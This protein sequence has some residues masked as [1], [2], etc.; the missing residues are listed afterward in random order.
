MIAVPSVVAELRFPGWA[1]ADQVPVADPDDSVGEV[2]AGLTMRRFESAGHIVACRADRFVGLARIEDVLAANPDCS[3][4]ELVDHDAPTIGPGVDAEIAAWRAVRHG[5]SALAVV[6]DDGVF[7]GLV[8]PRRIVEVLL[9]EHDE[10]VARFGGYL[11]SASSARHATEEPLTARLG[12]RLPWLVLG[13][14]GAV[15]AAGIVGRFEHDL[16]DHLLLA[17]FVPG[18]VYMADA[19]GTQTEAIVI[20]G[21]SVGVT[22]RHVIRGELITG[23]VIGAALAAAFVPIGLLLWG[24]V[25]VI[26]AVAV[27]LFAACSTATF[28]AMS[29][30]WAFSRL[31]RDPAFGSGPLA[32]VIQDLLSLLMYFALASWLVG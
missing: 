24:D 22:I 4:D 14:L 8:P 10:D 9:S 29:L 30:P 18:V 13:L 3:F 11:A 2:R 28:V 20:R 15:A 19:V 17:F 7:V 6:G 12:H 31:G 21:L 25:D 27:S 26:F 1:P 5:E 32:T 16:D 23:L